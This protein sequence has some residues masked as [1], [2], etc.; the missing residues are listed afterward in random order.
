MISVS[1]M[2][3]V[4][5]KSN[6]FPNLKILPIHS[7]PPSVIE[8]LSSS[9]SQ[10]SS[11]EHDSCFESSSSPYLNQ[12]QDVSEQ[13][14]RTSPVNSVGS[15]SNESTNYLNNLTQLTNFIEKSGVKNF[16]LLTN[17]VLSDGESNHD[18]DSAIHDSSNFQ[19]GTTNSDNL[20]GLDNILEEYNEN[21]ISN[22]MKQPMYNP[23]N[24]LLSQ[25]KENVPQSHAGSLPKQDTSFN[26]N[27]R[28]SPPTSNFIG[29]TA[30]GNISLMQNSGNMESS[31]GSP[32][33]IT[34]VDASVLG[35]SYN[36][37]SKKPGLLNGSTNESQESFLNVE[38]TVSNVLQGRIPPKNNHN[39]SKSRTSPSEFNHIESPNNLNYNQ[40]VNVTNAFYPSVTLDTANSSTHGPVSSYIQTFGSNSTSNLPLQVPATY[41]KSVQQSKFLMQSQSNTM[42]FGV[43]EPQSPLMFAPGI[44]KRSEMPYQAYAQNKL[45]Q[46]LV[47]EQ[48]NYLP[49][50]STNAFQ[51]AYNAEKRKLNSQVK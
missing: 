22:L 45:T 40:A 28:K 1:S 29:H 14:I 32:S 9:A 35:I 4:Q 19:R 6:D 39:K 15:I 12:E 48:F 43:T 31:Q 50:C 20:Q 46:H 49:N 23:E 34:T 8:K 27:L 24:Q 3:D 13:Y 7:H 2:Y 38:N 5:K 47:P 44:N 18:N 30:A 42:Q 11:G 33:N 16:N 41:P 51:M 10:E 26:K 21:F 17:S 37:F 25:S 36:P